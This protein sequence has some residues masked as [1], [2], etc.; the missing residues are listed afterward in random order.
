MSSPIP[1]L[2]G[3]LARVWGRLAGLKMAL[4]Q[5]TPGVNSFTTLGPKVCV[6]PTSPLY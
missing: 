3:N 6:Q 5:T 4:Y 2:I 1:Q